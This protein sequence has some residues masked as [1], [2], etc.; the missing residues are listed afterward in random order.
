[1]KALLSIRPGPASG[2]EL[3]DIPEPV[4]GPREVRIAVAA[5]GVNYPDVLL[6]EDLYQYK[7]ER[8]FS[9]GA[10]V[11][12]TVEVVGAEVSSLKPGDRV[13]T[14]M[15]WGG[16]AEKVTCPEASCTVLPGCVP[17]D[18][19][20]GGPGTSGELDRGHPALKQ[21]EAR[22][23]E[24]QA[25]LDAMT[26]EGDRLVKARQERTTVPP[27]RAPRARWRKR[28]Y[29]TTIVEA[30]PGLR[31]ACSCIRAVR[32]WQARRAAA[33]HLPTRLAIGAI[34]RLTHAIS[35]PYGFFLEDPI[36][37]G[38]SRII[39]SAARCRARAALTHVFFGVEPLR[40]LPSS[41]Q[42]LARACSSSTV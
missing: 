15:R 3:N 20:A 28:N 26:V 13:V 5:C 37:W 12:G 42:G 36:V 6:L 8:P 4:T 32:L 35:S 18:A 11:A 27:S 40:R 30:V 2:L 22:L 25:H 7:P 24:Q 34:L 33:E 1:M 16:M 17:F 29:L 41:G 19:A 39:V 14:W 23:R 31:W 10:E 9:P 21:A 38:S